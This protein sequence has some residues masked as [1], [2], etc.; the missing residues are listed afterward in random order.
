MPWLNVPHLQ[1]SEPGWCLPACVAMVTSFWQQPL[2][3]DDIA[4]WL[5]VR[6]IGVPANRIQQLARHGFKVFYGT[7][8]LAELQTWLAQGVPSILFIRTGE[9]PYW[10]VD[11]PHAVVLT[12]LEGESAYLLDPGVETSPVT[13]SVGDLML[14]WSHFDYTYAVLLAST[15]A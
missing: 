8:S 1:Q 5:G 9:F 7:G 3:Q 14:A 11:T 15:R 13:V 2:L 10:Q 4:H 12:G 6:G